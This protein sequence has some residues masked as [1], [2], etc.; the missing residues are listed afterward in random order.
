L[1]INL[2]LADDEN[3]HARI[4]PSPLNK[5]TGE[6]SIAYSVNP[7][8]DYKSITHVERRY[9]E[10]QMHGG[11]TVDDIES[12]YFLKP[13]SKQIMSLLDKRGIKYSI[14]EQ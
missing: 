13:P 11:V 10:V 1:D 9:S 7:K 6:S 4:V 12:V 2:G 14:K 3:S 5:I 8:H